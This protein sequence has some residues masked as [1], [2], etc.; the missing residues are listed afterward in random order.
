MVEWVEW[1]EGGV[2]VCALYCAQAGAFCSCCVMYTCAATHTCTFSHTLETHTTCTQHAT[3]TIHTACTHTHTIHAHSINMAADSPILVLSLGK[4]ILRAT[5]ELSLPLNTHSDVGRCGGEQGGVGRCD[6]GRCGVGRC[7]IG[8]CG[9][10]RC[11][12]GRCDV[13]RCGVGRCGCTFVG[14]HTVFLQYTRINTHTH[15][16]VYT[17]MQSHTHPL[18][19]SPPLPPLSGDAAALLTQ[20][21]PQA[22]TTIR[23]YLATARS[24]NVHISSE[25]GAAV[26]ADIVAARKADP[27]LEPKTLHVWL[28]VRVVDYWLT[29][30]GDHG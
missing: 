13:G 3:H 26:E 2:C 7:D 24:T 8:R 9:V 21:S 15:T 27:T 16:H 17:P 29:D 23:S 22:L 12:V 1:V 28:S 25:M 11:D 30:G 19:I 20:L 10:G 6:I 14:V 18:H 5:T 4:S